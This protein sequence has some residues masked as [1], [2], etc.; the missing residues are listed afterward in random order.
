MDISTAPFIHT[1]FVELTVVCPHF[2][3]LSNFL[4]SSFSTEQFPTMEKFLFQYNTILEAHKYDLDFKSKHVSKELLQQ[5]V[6]IMSSRND[7]CLL[8]LI[9]Q[10]ISMVLET[11]P[12]HAIQLFSISLHRAFFSIFRCGGTLVTQTVVNAYSVIVRGLSLVHKRMIE[13]SGAWPALIA[14]LDH[15]SSEVVN[16]VGQAMTTLVAGRVGEHYESFIHNGYFEPLIRALSPPPWYHLFPDWN[17]FWNWSNIPSIIIGVVG[18]FPLPMCCVPF[19]THLH[20]QLNKSGSAFASNAL[21]Q[22]TKL[23]RCRGS[24]L[25]F[26]CV[27][28]RSVLSPANHE[29]LLSAECHISAS[30]RIV[31]RHSWIRTAAL[32]FLATL[33]RYGH[34]S[35][36]AAVLPHLPLDRVRHIAEADPVAS[37]AAKRLLHVAAKPITLPLT[38]HRPKPV[39]SSQLQER[40]AA[41]RVLLTKPSTPPNLP[42][43]T[44]LTYFA[45]YLLSVSL[46]KRAKAAP[47]KMFSIFTDILTLMPDPPLVDGICLT[48]DTALRQ[49]AAWPIPEQIN[50]GYAKQVCTPQLAK[51]VCTLVGMG[52]DFA[53]SSVFAALRY[54]LESA[55][56]KALS[57]QDPAG[58]VE[59]CAEDDVGVVRRAAQD[60]LVSRVFAEYNQQRFPKPNFP[61][62]RESLSDLVLFRLIWWRL[63]FFLTDSNSFEVKGTKI[64]RTI[65][66]YET[67]VVLPP[68]NAVCSC[69][70]F[71][72]IPVLQGKWQ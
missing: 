11:N 18:P 25:L 27:R 56:F 23:A 7:H 50:W 8:S 47:P 5:F 68:Q 46:N 4:F 32:R 14:L 15:R 34:S 51:V 39:E 65:D 59:L 64:T 22:L 44:L 30:A 40:L 54:C 72:I 67:V 71:C 10:F 35:T 45:S 61:L 63:D 26:S 55:E 2:P 13:D 36:R 6:N 21:E 48:I 3:L 60:F 70:F 42:D 69:F 16:H 29:I 12:D 57:A 53:S 66:S 24:H 33:L 58:L 19:V 17:H 20:K 62:S 43:T 9:C 52:R 37:A 38:H 49:A 41:L 31:D 28:H 1:S